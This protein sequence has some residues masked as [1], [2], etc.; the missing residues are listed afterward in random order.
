MFFFSFNSIFWV[1][2]S[3]PNPNP[4]RGA[5]VWLPSNPKTNRDPDP[6][7][8]PNRGAIVRIPSFQYGNHFFILIDMKSQLTCFNVLFR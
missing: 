3:N 8:N 2:G 1:N 7:P 5:I 4:N 6:N